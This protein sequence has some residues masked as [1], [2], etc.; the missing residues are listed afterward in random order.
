M[1]P[2]ACESLARCLCRGFAPSVPLGWLGILSG[3]LKVARCVGLSCGKGGWVWPEAP[4][5]LSQLQSNIFPGDMGVS[6]NLCLL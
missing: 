6:L 2:E 5:L 4:A 3:P 1:G